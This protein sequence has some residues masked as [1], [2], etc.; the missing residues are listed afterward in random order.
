MQMIATVALPSGVAKI[1]E[2]AM[3]GLGFVVN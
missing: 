2:K 3:I 1:N